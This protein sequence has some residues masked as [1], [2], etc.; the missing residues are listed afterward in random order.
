MMQSDL[1]DDKRQGLNVE[2]NER[3]AATRRIEIYS[4]FSHHTKISRIFGEERTF[5]MHM[6]QSLLR[7]W[8]LDK[9]EGEVL[10]GLRYEW[11]FHLIVTEL[12]YM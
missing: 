8:H 10:L 11:K 6:R 7:G 9:E 4:G 1:L 3:S 2:I 12:L 5:I